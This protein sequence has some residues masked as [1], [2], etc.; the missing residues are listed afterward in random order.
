M[1]EQRFESVWDALADTP[2]EAANLQARSA[3]AIALT[4]VIKQRGLTQAEAAKRLGVTQPRVSDLMRGKLDLF[5]LDTL[6]N[7]LA[8]AGLRVE[9]R[10]HEDDPAHA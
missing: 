3:L 7:M 5:S 10:V 2:G 1:K 4:E 9:L 8:A 6:V